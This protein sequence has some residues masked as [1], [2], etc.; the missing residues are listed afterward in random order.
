MPE[1]FPLLSDIPERPEA[2]SKDVRVNEKR[3]RELVAELEAERSDLL[4]QLEKLRRAIVKG[5]E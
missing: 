4:E 1:V 5:K 3:Y 2:M